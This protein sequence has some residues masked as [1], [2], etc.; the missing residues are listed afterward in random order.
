MKSQYTVFFFY[1]HSTR[2]ELL[3]NSVSNPHLLTTSITQADVPSEGPYHPCTPV[4]VG[5]N[6][7]D[8]V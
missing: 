6:E 7:T 3:S 8:Q 1:V 2:Y 5:V 4:T